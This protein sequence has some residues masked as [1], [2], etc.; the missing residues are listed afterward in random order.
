MAILRRFMAN[1][2]IPTENQQIMFVPLM[3]KGAYYENI[4]LFFNGLFF[5]RN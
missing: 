1:S 2:D 4:L 5:L 3:N